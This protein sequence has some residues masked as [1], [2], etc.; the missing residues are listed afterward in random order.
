MLRDRSV[1]DFL[2]DQG[3]GRGGGAGVAEPTAL[4]DLAVAARLGY[5]VIHPPYSREAAIIAYLEEG[6]PLQRFCE[7]GGI[8]AYKV[9]PSA[10]SLEILEK[11]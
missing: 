5:V 1:R 9:V 4:R 10:R 3:R 8:V 6:L 11:K 7:R 2:S